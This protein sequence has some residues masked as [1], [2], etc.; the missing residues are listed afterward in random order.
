MSQVPWTLFCPRTG[1]T[2]TLG[3][4]KLPVNNA[5]EAIPL[6]TSTACPNWVTPIPHKITA[7]L[8]LAYSRAALR[9]SSALTPVITSAYSG[10]YLATFA[11]Y[12]AK[13][14]VNLAT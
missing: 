14:S 1:P 8:A 12:S 5:N 9:I 2:P 13:P 10:V 3:R 11:L 4:P 6:I 7:F